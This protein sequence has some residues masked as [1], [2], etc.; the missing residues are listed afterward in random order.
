[1]IFVTLGTQKQKFFILISYLKHCKGKLIVQNGYTP[2]S[3]TH[4]NFLEYDKMQSYIKKA[5]YIISH[6]GISVMEAL[7]LNKK[8]IVVPREKRFH[9][10]ISDHQFEIC[11]YLEE[12]GYI[13]L[14][15]TEKEFINKLK[16][17]A[18]FKPR[19]YISK[20]EKFYQNFDEIIKEFLNFLD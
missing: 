11:K 2:C 1:M 6:G 16:E 13:L 20:S 15:R 9:E 5:D 18:T 10:H 7:K 17:I 19:K 4:Y 12:N 3:Y 14:A 8:V